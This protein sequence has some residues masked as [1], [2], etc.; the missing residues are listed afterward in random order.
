MNEPIADAARG[1]LDGHIVLERKLANKG[2]YPAIDVLASIS[3][4]MK[5]VVTPEHKAA[6]KRVQG[7]PGRLYGGRRT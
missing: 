2:H 4:C 1:I 5:D 7:A 6:A 3:R